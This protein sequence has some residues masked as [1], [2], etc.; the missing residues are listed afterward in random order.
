MSVPPLLTIA[1]LRAW[2]RVEDPTEDATLLALAA[3]AERHVEEITGQV[4][5]RRTEV[6]RDTAWPDAGW[7]LIRFPVIRVVEIGYIDS[8]GAA[9]QLPGTVWVLDQGK[10]SL[11]RRR[12]GQSWPAIQDDS[13]I[14]VVLDVGYPDQ[15]C[16][17][18]LKTACLHLVAHWF[19]NRGAV[20]VGN[21]VTE[22]PVTVASLVAPFR[23]SLIG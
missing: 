20:N 8:A 7:E 14:M 1:E 15:S 6:I 3:S 19:D 21:I 22:M 18:G 2:C 5:T 4:L 12:T 23:L 17:P 11:L 9:Q 13:E 10:R 16:P